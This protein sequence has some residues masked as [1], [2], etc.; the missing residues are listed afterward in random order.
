MPARVL[1]SIGC[2][3]YQYLK[4]LHGAVLDAEAMHQELAGS[5]YSRINDSDAYLLTS[6]STADLVE[7]LAAIQ[8]KYPE[9]ESLT[10]FFAGHGGESN[11]SYYLC[12]TETRS[13]RLSTTGYPLS[14]LF[15]FLNELKA[16]HC[17]III[18]ACN[19]GGMVSD[20]HA[21]LKPAVIGSAHTF[22]VSL[23]IS[24][25]ADQYAKE[26]AQG[27]YGTTGI[28]KVLRGEIDTGVRGAFLDLL[29]I[30][31]AAASYVAEAT[32]YAQMPSVW[33]VNLYGHM[34]LF[35]NPH[36]GG[37][38]A[39]SLLKLTGISPRSAA[40]RAISEGAGALYSLVHSAES[41]LTPRM[42][43]DTLPE[44]VDRLTDMPGAAAVF[45][46]GI[47]RSLEKHARQ[48]S[49]TFGALELS[50]CCI[51]LLLESSERDP[52]SAAYLDRFGHELLDECERLL[53]ELAQNLTKHH[54]S[55][56]NNGIPDLFF[57]P[58][59]IARILGWAGAGIHLARELGRDEGMIRVS[60]GEICAVLSQHYAPSCAGMSETE[61][62]FWA[63]FLSAINEHDM[64]GFGELILSTL[65]N[66]LIENGGALAK[67]HLDA[68]EIYSYLL[69]RLEKDNEAMRPHTHSPSELLSVA[70]LLAPRYGLQHTADTNLELLDHESLFIFIPEDYLEFSK[71]CVRNGI[72]NVFQIGHKVWTVAD[73]I[74]RWNEACV[75]QIH[76]SSSI[77]RPATRI[78]AICASLLFPDRVPWFL[79][80]DAN[81]D[82]PL[83]KTQ[84]FI[85]QIKAPT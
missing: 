37:D 46:D 76:R 7:T 59:R 18:D 83:P 1:L 27:G 8:D 79:L 81:R 85:R 22:G 42:I 39:S 2:D 29:D 25:A 57:L 65:L 82:L 50:A 80:T 47:W 33:G 84:T 32:G 28:L 38:S 43:F 62:P 30:G 14:R 70:L 68:K 12:M 49:N 15:E 48:G 52:N 45:V 9:L 77:Q 55:L 20:L 24:S 73:L 3:D 74:Q 63:T 16:A 41:E 13:D 67:P 40:G 51:A 60:L 36:A 64:E 35:N 31:K 34:P 53:P 10:I 23:F 58:Q 19:A 61:A 44:F 21:L 5:E 6:P 4:G 71:P 17:N 26:D 72:N 69:A 54:F 56:C 66:A 75:P 78:G 11:G